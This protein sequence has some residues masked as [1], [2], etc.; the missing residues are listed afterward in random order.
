MAEAEFFGIWINYLIRICRP[1]ITYNI[2]RFYYLETYNFV[3]KQN[4]C[5]FQT[6]VNAELL[7][8]LF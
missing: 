3:R 4:Y 2:G 6:Q 7:G 5:S 1:I 8:K